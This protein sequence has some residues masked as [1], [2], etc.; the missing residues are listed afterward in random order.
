MEALG[1]LPQF[2][3]TLC[4]DHW[5]PYY[6]YDC[7]HALCNA[8]H[9]RELTHAF[10]Q[11]QQ[12][13]A[14]AMQ[15]LL[16][17]INAKTL[18]AGGALTPDSQE[19]YRLKYRIIIGEGNAESPPP[20]D[21]RKTGQRGRIKRSKSRNLLERLRD[22]EDDVLRFMCS[23]EVPFTN[24]QGERDIRMTKVQQKISGCFRSMEGAKIFCRVR[25]YLSTCKKQ[26]ISATTALA[27][28]FQGKLPDF[29]SGLE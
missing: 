3:G 7:H 18:E 23:P 8:H 16:K 19:A 22:Y 12:K 10:E 14:K 27:L 5:K 25:S 4:H 11:D 9:L 28:L 24:N 6:K 13:W 1:I 15:D 26:G 2:T 20:D 17:E 29:D 21:P